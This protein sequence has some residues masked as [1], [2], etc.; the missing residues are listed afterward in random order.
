M[1]TEESR[2]NQVNGVYKCSYTGHFIPHNIF[3]IQVGLFPSLRFDYIRQ[4]YS[5]PCTYV[6][7]VV[8]FRLD[9]LAELASHMRLTYVQ[10]PH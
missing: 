10:F 8:L 9:Q 6:L 1:Y 4:I 3:F 7:V 5:T 2:R